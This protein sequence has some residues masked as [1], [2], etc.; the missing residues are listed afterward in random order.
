VAC[1]GLSCH[2]ISSVIVQVVVFLL[3]DNSELV[4]GACCLPFRTLTI[5]NWFLLR[6]SY[7]TAGVLNSEYMTISLDKAHNNKD[8]PKRNSFVDVHT[9]QDCK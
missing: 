6:P 5:A 1:F 3:D 8:T 2:I 4:L 9:K 7:V